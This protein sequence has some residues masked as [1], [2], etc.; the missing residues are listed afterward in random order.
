MKDQPS[1]PG[2]GLAGARPSHLFHEAYLAW[3]VIVRAEKLTFSAYATR[4]Q[5]TLSDFWCILALRRADDAGRPEP[6]RRCGSASSWCPSPRRTRG[7]GMD[8]A[9]ALGT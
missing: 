3:R 4:T 1:N 9:A 6:S 2:T 5:L 8:S 7:T